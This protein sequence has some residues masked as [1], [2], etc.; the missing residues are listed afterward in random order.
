MPKLRSKKRDPIC[1]ETLYCSFC[2]KSQHQVKKLIAGP[3][4]YI[5]D[6]CV[7]VCMDI[8]RPKRRRKA[9]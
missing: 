9:A 5:C 1:R 3:A 4:V 7:D 8:V 2:S 6:E